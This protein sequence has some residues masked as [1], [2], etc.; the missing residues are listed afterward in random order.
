MWHSATR[1]KRPSRETK[2]LKISPDKEH[3]TRRQMIQEGWRFECRAEKADGTI[4]LLFW[5]PK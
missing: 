5:H 2:V 4:A 1:M 3:E